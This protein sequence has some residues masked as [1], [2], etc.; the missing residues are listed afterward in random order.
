ME[1]CEWCTAEVEIEGGENAVWAIYFVIVPCHL[2]ICLRAKQV[3][4]WSGWELVYILEED[5]RDPAEFI[6]WASNGLLGVLLVRELARFFS[7]LAR[8]K[9][10]MLSC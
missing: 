9:S 2:F 10:L 5:G 3:K 8:K 7:F 4:Q 1:F 6:F